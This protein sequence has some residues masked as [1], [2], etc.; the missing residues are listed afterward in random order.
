MKAMKIELTG[1]V[2]FLLLLLVVACKKDKDP[3]PSAVELTVEKLTSSGWVLNKLTVDEV[4]Q[5]S[6]FRDLTLSFTATSFTTTNG[7]PVWPTT[8]TWS[9]TD[10]TATEILR[11]DGVTIIIEEVS[12][13]KLELSLMWDETSF[14]EGRKKSIEGNH[15]FT[16]TR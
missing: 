15:V 3:Q 9:F 2:L 8:G 5:T 14:A 7:D 10:D 11:S 16:F 1:V 12:S 4:D 6:L 13:T